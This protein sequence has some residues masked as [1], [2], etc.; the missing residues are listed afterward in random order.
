MAD[1]HWL[2]ADEL[3]TGLDKVRQS[4]KDVGLLAYIVRRPES[5]ER[6][7]LAEA[8]LDSVLGLVGDNWMARGSRHTPDG[9]A[10]PDMQLTVMNARA[11]ALVAQNED[12]W[13][14]AGDQLYIDID[15]SVDNL[16]AGIRLA[17]GSAVI[18]VTSESHTGCKHFAA[19]FGHGDEVRQLDLGKATAAAG[20]ERKGRAVGNRS[21]RR[22][23]DEIAQLTAKRRH[24]QAHERHRQQ[25][26]VLLVQAGHAVP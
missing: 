17:V 14:L 2:T 7:V 23:G 25:E 15:L 22:R 9:S 1:D 3:E 10:H 18:E 8:A 19:R 20:S 24:L 12:R 21:R 11:I 6:E 16:P 13:K 5:G 26:S 4:P